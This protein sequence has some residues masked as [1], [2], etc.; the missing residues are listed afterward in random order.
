MKIENLSYGL[1]KIELCEFYKPCELFCLEPLINILRKLHKTKF[2]GCSRKFYH[3]V[4]YM[5]VAPSMDHILFNLN[6]PFK[7]ILRRFEVVFW[8]LEW[9]CCNF[10]KIDGNSFKSTNTTCIMDLIIFSLQEACETIFKGNL[11]YISFAFPT[12][13]TYWFLWRTKDRILHSWPVKRS[14][15]DHCHKVQP[16]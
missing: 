14:R 7:W 1:C 10:W 6:L 16:L 9:E 8:C 15:Q 4:M 5:H 3:R 2:L 13:Q 11:Q 12:M